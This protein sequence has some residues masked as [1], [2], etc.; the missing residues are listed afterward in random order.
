METPI[1]YSILQ[2]ENGDSRNQTD[3]LK[4][5]ESGL[6]GQVLRALLPPTPQS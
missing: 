4:L 5:Q 3:S 2:M 1:I 6:D